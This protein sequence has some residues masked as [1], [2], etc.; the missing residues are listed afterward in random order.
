VTLTANPY[1]QQRQQYLRESV[2]SAT[3][4][5]LLTMLYD[6]LLLDLQRAESAQAAQNWAAASEQLKHAQEIVTELS[7]SLKL[8][9][10]DGAD[11]LLGI[12][13]YVSNA[14]MTANVHRNIDATRECIV[15]LEP[16]RQAWHEA[17]AA[18]P[19]QAAAPR[20]IGNL[21]VA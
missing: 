18:I 8:D 12:Y 20:P 19:V 9:V 7:S 5:R 4:A 6:R 13:N 16:L 11:N 14:M 2:L 15:L 1:A 17:A 10:W 21:G 3:P